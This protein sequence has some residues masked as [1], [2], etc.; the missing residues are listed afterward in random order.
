MKV[1]KID[2]FFFLSIEEYL[3]KIIQYMYKVPNVNIKGV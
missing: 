3:T 1:L 2:T